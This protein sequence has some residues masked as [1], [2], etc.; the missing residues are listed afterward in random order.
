MRALANDVIN[1]RIKAIE[2]GEEIPMDALSQILKLS[3]IIHLLIA[4]SV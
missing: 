4:V 2:S 3:S 1:A